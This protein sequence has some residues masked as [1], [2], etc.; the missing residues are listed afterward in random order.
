MDNYTTKV[1]REHVA[2][3]QSVNEDVLGSYRED[4]E[5]G[6]LLSNYQH[7]LSRQ[8]PPHQ[9]RSA[10]VVTIFMLIMLCC[11]ITALGVLFVLR[12]ELS[13]KPGTYETGFHTELGKDATETK[14][15]LERTKANTTEVP[16][17]PQIELM[18]RRFTG[19]LRFDKS[20]M[21]YR[22]T[23]PGVTQYVGEPS[24]ELDVAWFDLYER[25]Q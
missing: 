11:L 4:D 16:A 24:D 5:T 13:E 17:F 3:T 9:K 18:K 23:E 6:G 22:V 8:E 7:H 25:K 12:L 1:H 14:Q 10:Y 20:G 19:G 21:L 15:L 2:S